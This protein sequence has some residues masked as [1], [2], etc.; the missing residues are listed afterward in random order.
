MI[1]I[2]LISVNEF[3]TNQFLFDTADS[4]ILQKRCRDLADNYEALNEKLSDSSIPLEDLK[5]RLRSSNEALVKA[6]S[7]VQEL[8][9][10][11]ADLESIPVLKGK[12]MKPGSAGVSSVMEDQ[13][14]PDEIDKLKSSLAE[15]NSKLSS[16]E[17]S[18]ASLTQQLESK[19]QELSFIQG[20]GCRGRL[21]ILHCC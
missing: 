4:E 17:G 7:E 13:D 19:K 14:E 9:K 2:Y 5:N 16:A 21:S 12:P 11:L 20:L 15:A 3:L 8:T 6:E 10:K 18:L 1:I